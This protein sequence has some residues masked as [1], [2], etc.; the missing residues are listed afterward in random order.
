M[1]HFLL[2]SPLVVIDEIHTILNEGFR[3][4]YESLTQLPSFG[5]PILTMSGSLPWQ[6]CSSL[7]RY[8]GVS[9][10]DGASLLGSGGV[11]LIGGGD[12]LGDFPLDFTFGCEVVW[13]PRELSIRSACSSVKRNPSHAVHIMVA[14]KDD[15]TYI[16]S[17]IGEASI[18]HRVLTSDVDL[19]QQQAIAKDWRNSQFSI[20]VSTSIAIVGNENPDCRHLVLNGYLFNIIT[21]VQAINHRL[22]PRQRHGGA[23]IRIFLPRRPPD[24]F[25]AVWDKKEEPAFTS[26]SG[27]GLIPHDA[28][29]W[30]SFWSIGGLHRWLIAEEG[31]CTLPFTGLQ[32]PTRPK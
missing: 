20:L 31:C 4:V 14:A 17:K 11:R 6:F 26:L 3:P 16:A 24:F 22:R 27:K 21:I 9:T 13:S 32:R 1:S 15:A 19:E 10:D 28:N 5:T 12:V 18:S 7:L 23:S 2:P 8:I 29:L 25:D 30:K